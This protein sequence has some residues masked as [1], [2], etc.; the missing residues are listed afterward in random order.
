MDV[1]KSTVADERPETSLVGLLGEQRAAIVEHLRQEPGAT[2]A[3]LAEVL[4]VS[5][6]ATRRHVALLE[7]EGFVVGEAV[8]NGRGRPAVRYRLTDRARGLFPQRYA[9]VASELIDF[10]STE[11]G[12]DGLR[13]YLRWRLERETSAYS[14]IVT[15]DELGDKLSQLADALSEAGYDAE[16]REDGDGYVLEQGHC[17]IYDVA[18]HHPE[19]CTYEAATFS[20]VLGR[21]V[22]LSRRETIAGGSAACVCTVAPKQRTSTDQ[23]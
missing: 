13:A 19:M 18:K 2:I 7:D 15:A 11:H 17:A 3:D 20:K 14:D 16:V 1:E 9:A 6:V 5:D 4:G 21:D 12:R 23:A 8:S 10:I 22:T